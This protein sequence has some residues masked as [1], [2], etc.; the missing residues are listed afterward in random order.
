M[1]IH[2]K[3]EKGNKSQVG[4]PM[5]GTVIDIRVKPGDKIEKGSPLVILTAMKMETIVQSPTGGTVKTV[6][7]KMGMKLEAEDLLITLE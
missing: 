3:A 2:P 6:D 5:P 1:H 4:A 7:V